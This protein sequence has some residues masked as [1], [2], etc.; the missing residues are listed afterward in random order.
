MRFCKKLRRSY[1]GALKK[2]KFNFELFFGIF[3]IILEHFVNFLKWPEKK[4]EVI[5]RSIVCPFLSFPRG[6][7][8][9]YYAMEIC[10]ASFHC[11][12]YLILLIVAQYCYVRFSNNER[13]G[14]FQTSNKFLIGSNFIWQSLYLLSWGDTNVTVWS[15]ILLFCV[16]L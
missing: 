9:Y 14:T 2:W 8:E 4:F 13:A 12:I 5:F 10:D 15:I 3:G 16:L 11:S 6:A 1:L 7:M